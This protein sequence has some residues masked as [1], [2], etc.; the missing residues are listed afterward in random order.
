MNIVIVEGFVATEPEFKETAKSQLC[1]FRLGVPRKWSG[2]DGSEKKSDFFSVKV[3][4]RDAEYASNN[5]SKGDR[6]RVENGRVEIEEWNKQDGSTGTVVA[7]T[8]A[9]GAFVKVQSYNKDKDATDK[10]K[11]KAKDIPVEEPE[12]G[13]YDPFSEE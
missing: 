1:T 10:P 7:I 3:W 4:G 11:P 12:E 9:P 2:K 8:A 6:I 13:E 5:I